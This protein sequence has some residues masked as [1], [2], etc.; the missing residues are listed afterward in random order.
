MTIQHEDCFCDTWETKEGEEILYC[1][2]ETPHL[3]AIIKMLWRQES[4]GWN[5][6]MVV[7]GEQAGYAIEDGIAQIESLIEDLQ[8]E[9]ASRTDPF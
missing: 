4:A 8:A 6:L 3:R 1:Q 2:L 5:A 7:N 9:L